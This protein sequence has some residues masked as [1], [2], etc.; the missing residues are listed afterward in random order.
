MKKSV[1][2]SVFAAAL[3]ASCA[4]APQGN[5][6]VFLKEGAFRADSIRLAIGEVAVRRAGGSWVTVPGDTRTV[7]LVRLAA[8]H[9][10]LVAGDLAPGSYSGIHLLITGAQ[11]TVGGRTFDL[12]VPNAEIRIQAP[13]TIVRGRATD[14]IL[15][16]DA[17]ESLVF[18]P[19]GSGE[20]VLRPVFSF[21][22]VYY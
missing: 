3:F 21:V 8:R 6:R 13:F 1:F 19:P 11:M 12:S 4:Q 2:L 18:G 7:D 10:D 17:D 9:E 22:S 20:G 15:D 5:F 16:F 14:I